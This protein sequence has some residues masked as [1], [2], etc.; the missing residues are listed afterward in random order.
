VGF[1][2]EDSKKYTLAKTISWYVIHIT[3]MV[4]IGYI[5]TGSFA[6]GIAIALLETLGESVLYYTH[7]RSWLRIRKRFE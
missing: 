4:L 6:V 1:L 2:R 5:L 7:E 3:W